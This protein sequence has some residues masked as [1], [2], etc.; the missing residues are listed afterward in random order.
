MT[1]RGQ[2]SRESFSKQSSL[3]KGGMEIFFFSGT[4]PVH[5]EAPEVSPYL[6]PMAFLGHLCSASCIPLVQH[7]PNGDPEGTN[8]SLTFSSRAKTLPRFLSTSR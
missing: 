6:S 4:V 8:K 7:S 3:R 2:R 1:C 5:R